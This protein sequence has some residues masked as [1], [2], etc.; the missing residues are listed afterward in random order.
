[1]LIVKFDH[2]HLH[3]VHRSYHLRP[4]K[5]IW[6][7]LTTMTTKKLVNSF[8]ISRV[9]YCNSILAGIPKYQISHVQSILN[10]AARVIYGQAR[11]DHVTPT[12]RDRLHWLYVPERIQFKR[13][14]LVYKVLH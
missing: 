7:L 14:L 6:R 5:F 11:F 8:I 13:C 3:D 12:L 9:D 2:E 4:I 1:M 10:V